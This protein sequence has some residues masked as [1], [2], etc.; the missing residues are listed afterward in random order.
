MRQK[1]NKY[2]ERLLQ[3]IWEETEFTT[4][5]LESDC[6]SM[7][8]I[9]DPG[10][11]N[12]GEGPDFLR[13][14]IKLDGIELHGSVEIHR[15]ASEWITHKHQTEKNF[16]SVILHVVYENDRPGKVYRSD[17]TQPVTISIKPYLSS[18]L[19]KLARLKET[20]GLLCKDNLMFIHQE[21][22]EEQIRK[23][24]K[25]YFT[26]KVDEVLQKYE[27]RGMISESWKNAMIIQIYRTLGI[28]VNRDQMQQLA[29]QI[30]EEK[31]VPN[32]QK[33]FVD[34]VN[35]VA[36]NPKKRKFTIAWRHTG[37]RPA[38]RPE[39]RVAQ[40]AAFHY[41][42]KNQPLEIF[43]EDPTCSWEA[44]SNSIGQDSIPGI[45]TLNLIKKTVFLPSIY[46]LG[47]LLFSSMLM[48]R[49]FETWIEEPHQ[50]PE[51]IKKPFLDAGFLIKNGA[52]S[53]GLAHQLK[54]YCKRRECHNCILF[55]N[56]IRS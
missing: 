33:K 2:K 3:W 17:G 11:L 19:N 29:L 34:L 39:V 6:G 43:L 24:T 10:E 51:M 14:R 12:H 40:A 7:V 32:S 21:A 48:E 1:K 16:D 46:L 53:I 5:L 13:S 56:A 49:S 15:L 31:T 26:Y 36:F 8:E 27:P 38:S 30:I 55:K 35:E 18:P 42:I 50:L 52:G 4:T 22:F 37:M 9:L 45:N 41:Q 54:R 44:L 25:E 28:P 20:N 23:A 47:Q